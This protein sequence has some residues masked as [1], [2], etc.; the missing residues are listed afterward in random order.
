MRKICWFFPWLLLVPLLGQEQPPP[1][2]AAQE[3]QPAAPQSVGTQSAGIQQDSNHDQAQKKRDDRL[4][5]ALPNYLTVE[6][7][8]KVPPL[9]VGEKFKL[10]AQGAFDYAEFAWYGMLAGISQAR[11]SDHE[12]GQGAEG[13]GKR[14]GEALGDGAIENF[15]SKAVLPSLLHEDPRY[16]QLGKGRFW[17]RAGYAVSRVFITRTDTGQSRFDFSEILGSGSAAAIST[18]SYHPESDRNLSSIAEVWGAQIGYDA[19]SCVA[20]E[21]WPDIRRKLHRSKEDRANTR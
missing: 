3:E 21:F 11:N 2:T 5:F 1:D 18:Y 7:A 19:L 12:Y 14:Y 16:Y 9:T 20:K 8:G 10:T 15:M 13:Y 17:H 4:F 6:N